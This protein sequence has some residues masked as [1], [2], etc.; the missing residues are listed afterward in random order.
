VNR[1][2][3]SHDQA[4]VV[5]FAGA[6]R[7]WA[8]RRAATRYPAL[9]LLTD[10]EGRCYTRVVLSVPALVELATLLDTQP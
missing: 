2:Y 6:L 4:A 9:L 7:R 5:R 8:G 3:Q 1:P 10:A